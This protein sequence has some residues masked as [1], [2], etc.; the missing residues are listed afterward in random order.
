MQITF[1]NL[2]QAVTM[3]IDKLDALEKLIRSNNPSKL[4]ESD[5]IFNIDQAAIFTDL[6]VPTIYSKVHKREIPVC[7]QG[8]RLYFSKQELTAWIKSGRK[9]TTIEIVAE[10]HRSIITSK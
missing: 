8:G 4:P 9:R 5:E 7:K 3:L 2:P 1:D 6:A 10:A